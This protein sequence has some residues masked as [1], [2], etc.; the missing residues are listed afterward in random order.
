MSDYLWNKQGSDEEIELLE[1][2]LG[3]FS[4]DSSERSAATEINSESW[5]SKL[6]MFWKLTPVFASCLLL[7]ILFFYPMD[8]GS[9]DA[10]KGPMITEVKMGLKK[11]AGNLESV[12]GTLVR[13]ELVTSPNVS[14]P[15]Q[16]AR[17]RRNRRTK[18]PRVSRTSRR[19]TGTKNKVAQKTQ[20]KPE[21]AEVSPGDPIS[22]EE[23]AAFEELKKALAITSSNLSILKEKVNGDGEDSSSDIKE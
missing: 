2:R 21:N 19:S 15:V 9:F 4:S 8:E 16:T 7:G 23:R 10:V 6:A 3:S 14:R 1:K 5:F 22:A 13:P 18:V 11:P 12:S 20:P 17:D